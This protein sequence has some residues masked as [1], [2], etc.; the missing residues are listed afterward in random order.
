MIE[1][2][3]NR[4]PLKALAAST[5]TGGI[6]ALALTMDLYVG[7]PY[8]PDLA[9]TA[10]AG[11]ALMV[12][13]SLFG[14]GALFAFFWIWP[15][16]L[17]MTLVAGR[18][19]S[20]WPIGRGWPAWLGL[21]AVGGGPALWLYSFPLGLGRDLLDILFLNGAIFGLFC[22]ATLRALIGP[23]IINRAIGTHDEQAQHAS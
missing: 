3:R 18:L 11:D 21:G 8:G 19:E 23:Q 13:L 16:A 10:N 7:S 6:A 14:L 22:A 4:L 12:T 1:R 15:V 2:S 17:A 5:L 20:R 9:Y